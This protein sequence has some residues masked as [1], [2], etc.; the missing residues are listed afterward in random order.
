MLQHRRGLSL[1]IATSYM[2]LVT[3]AALFHNHGDIACTSAH[4]GGPAAQATGHVPEDAA[5]HSHHDGSFPAHRPT[6]SDDRCP[7]CQFLAQRTI[8]VGDVA[9]V[10]SVP[11]EQ[12]VALAAPMRAASRIPSCWHSRAPPALG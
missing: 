10:T 3:T 6:S 1:L 11:L 9:L 5:H 8:P 7:V 4:R 2:L 12:A